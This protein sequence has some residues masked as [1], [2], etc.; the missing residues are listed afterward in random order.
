MA[1]IERS[2]HIE[3]EVGWDYDA[4]SERIQTP[5]DRFTDKE[6]GKAATFH[7]QTDGDEEMHLTI[8]EQHNLVRLA[9]GEYDL[10]LPNQQPPQ[11]GEHGILFHS[12]HG[13]LAISN[14]G[15]AVLAMGN[16]EYLSSLRSFSPSRS[17]SSSLIQPETDIQAPP[18]P[19]PQEATRAQAEQ[20]EQQ[21]LLYLRE[22]R[23]GCEP[24]FRMT[25]NGKLVGELAVYVEDE[26]GDR[27]RYPVLLFNDRAEALQRANLKTGDLVDVKGY[28]HP[29][30][31]RD[32]KTGED[33]TVEEVYA[34]LVT[35]RDAEGQPIAVVG[36]PPSSTRSQ[37]NS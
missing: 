26:Q 36:K 16:E 30:I 3:Q 20:R 31:I 13:T 22:G 5:A 19:A 8:Y 34:F 37:R 12:K 14:T 4:I 29:K 18:E 21:E 2:P 10:S 35:T 23:L 28:A 17:E 24:H 15:S 1:D 11:L 32:A 7:I 25:R 6:C 33:K 9:Y 27:Q